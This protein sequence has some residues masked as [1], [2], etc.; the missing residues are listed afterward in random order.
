[1]AV[2]CR[3]PGEYVVILA[4]SRGRSPSNRCSTADPPTTY[5]GAPVDLWGGLDYIQQQARAG[6]FAGQYEFD[7]AIMEHFNSANEGHLSVIPC[8]T[9]V[10][11][12]QV[13]Q[14]LVSVSSDGFELPH[15]Y[16]MSMSSSLEIH[17]ERKQAH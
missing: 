9:G 17:R 11:S 6:D 1:M 15:V 12:F 16:T 10:F 14:Q 3:Y 8:S 4:S 2:D 13:D 7:N 5:L